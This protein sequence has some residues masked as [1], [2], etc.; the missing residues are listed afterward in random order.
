MR[1]MIDPKTVGGAGQKKYYNHYISLKT[2]YSG[3]NYDTRIWFN[4]INS[5]KDK[6]TDVNE[7][8][9]ALPNGVWFV[10]TGYDQLKS[11]ENKTS[12]IY[13]ISKSGSGEKPLALNIMSYVM[14]QAEDKTVTFNKY[15]YISYTGISNFGIV[16][17]VVVE[18]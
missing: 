2:T 4:I 14:T 17:D 12:F 18:L 16:A 8:Y 10:A 5:R 1:R 7:L 9:D 3:S 11:D 15:P 13:T 6:Y